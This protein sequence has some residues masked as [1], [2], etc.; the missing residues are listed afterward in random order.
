MLESAHRTPAQTFLCKD[1]VGDTINCFAEINIHWSP[2]ILTA[3]YQ[4]NQ[5]WFPLVNPCWQHLIAF[6]SFNCSDMA[7]RTSCSITWMEHLKDGDETNWSIVYWIVLL[8]LMSGVPLAIF[9]FSVTSSILQNLSR[10]I[11]SSFAIYQLSNQSWMNSI[12]A[13]GLVHNNF[14]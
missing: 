7:S 14:A 13:H 12:G 9:L 3:S 1:V 4:V 11:E 2:F 10:M 8:D 6:F 5:T